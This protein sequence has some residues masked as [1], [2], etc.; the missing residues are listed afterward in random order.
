M[1]DEVLKTKQGVLPRFVPLVR[2]VPS[3]IRFDWKR[4]NSA[5]VTSA[6]DLPRYLVLGPLDEESFARDEGGWQAT[7][8]TTDGSDGWLRIGFNSS[9]AL[10]SLQHSW[11]GIY[12]GFSQFLG[13]MQLGQILAQGLYLRF[14][15]WWDSAAKDLPEAT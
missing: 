11:R 2:H 4:F 5:A 6:T 15:A 12:G 1:S 7:W 3:R 14:P 8:R 10:Y 13:R 9:N